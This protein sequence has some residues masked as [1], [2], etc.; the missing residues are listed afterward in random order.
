MRDKLNNMSIIFIYAID[1]LAKIVTFIVVLVAIAF[2]M[3]AMFMGV[4]GKLV[5]TIEE[6]TISTVEVVD[7]DVVYLHNR[8]H[9]IDK[10]TLYVNID[11]KRVS[12][13]V[14]DMLYE[15]I[16]V[17]DTLD[18]FIWDTGFSKRVE[19]VN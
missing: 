8:F 12:I 1:A 6:P 15:C 11:D 3:V 14:S 10:P 16:E 17:G 7:K 18:V 5:S 2:T 4:S 9:S 13:T 19:L